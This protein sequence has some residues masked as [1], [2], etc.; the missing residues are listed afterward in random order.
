MRLLIDGNLDALGN[1]KLHGVRFAEREGDVLALEFGAVADTDDVEL[2]LEALGDAVNGIGEKRSSQAMQRAMFVVIANRAEHAIFL[3]E[4]DLR[5][6]QHAELAL[7]A[8]H[9]DLATA[10]GRDL[11]AGGNWNWFATNT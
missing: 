4:L 9:F 5:R 10:D 3:L 1:L 6:N 2:L 8:L 7:G 11:H